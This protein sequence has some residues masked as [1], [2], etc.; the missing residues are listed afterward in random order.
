MF[1]QFHLYGAAVWFLIVRLFYQ[2][3]IL[4]I[5]SNK[6]SIN[7]S[8]NHIFRKFVTFAVFYSDRIT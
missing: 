8:I 3:F 5:Q 7:Q 4:I 6:Q 1:L 2:M